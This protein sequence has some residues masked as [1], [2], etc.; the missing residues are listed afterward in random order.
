MRYFWCNFLLTSLNKYLLIGFEILICLF[1]FFCFIFSL[2]VLYWVIFWVEMGSEKFLGLCS[3]RRITFF[4]YDFLFFWIFD[5]LLFGVILRLLGPCRVIFGYGCF[6]VRFVVVVGLG[7]F[8]T[9]WTLWAFLGGGVGFENC[10]RVH[11]CNWTTFI[12]F[13]FWLLTLT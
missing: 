2:F 10:F 9:F 13:L 11:S 5:I 3:Y 4:L 7:S 8:L 6:V 1:C 12:F